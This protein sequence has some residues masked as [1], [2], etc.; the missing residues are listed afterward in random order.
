M[1]QFLLAALLISSF[2]SIF[3]QATPGII[4]NVKYGGSGDDRFC[5]IIRLNNGSYIC[6]G[7][8][9]STNGQATGNHGGSD[10][11]IVCI[12]P[13]GQ[14]LWRKVIGGS[15]DD[16]GNFVGNGEFLSPTADGGFYFGGATSSSNGDIPLQR[17]SYDIFISRFDANGNI[18]WKKTYGGS[19]TE[20]MSSIQTTSDGG[21]IF[22]ATTSS[23]SNGDV[24]ANHGSSDVWIVK[25]DETGAIQWNKLF[26][27]TKA[28]T[29]IRMITTTDGGY[30]FTAD[31]SSE[32]GDLTGTVPVGA[33]RRTD[34]WVVKLASDGSLTWQKRIGGSDSDDGAKIIQST[35]GDYYVLASSRSIDGDFIS[36][37]GLYDWAF[38]KLTNGGTV[39]FIK[40]IGGLAW[41][42]SNDLAEAEDGNFLLTGITYSTQMGGITV[43]NKGSS[44]IVLAKVDK[45]NGNLQW[46]STIG[47]T[48]GD[49]PTAIYK[50]PG[51]ETM[52]VGSSGSS[53]G[54]M[55]MGLGGSDAFIIGI[56]PYN[57]VKG[58][59]FY[60]YNGN[61]TKE[62]TEPFVQNVNVTTTKNNVY[63]V[64]SYTESGNYF[65]EVD[66]G[67][68]VTKPRIF[69]ENYY[70]IT[71]DSFTNTFPTYYGTV[72]RNFGLKPIRGKRDLRSALVAINPARAGF[73][74]YY[75]LIC[76]NA[77]TDTVATGTVKLIK[78]S[79]TTYVSSTPTHLNVSGDTITWVY[80]NFK[81]LDTL[82]FNIVID[83]AVP[84][85]IKIGDWIKYVSVIGP[86]MGDLQPGDNTF[87]L[88]HKVTGSYDP[89]D[90]SE[91]HG[92]FYT[93]SAL[94]KREPLMYTI[95]FQNTG[96]DTAF[97]IVVKDTLD[98]KL[99]LKSF[100]LLATSHKTKL[101]IT[102]NI[103]TWKFSN[104]L[105]PDSNR[106][107]PASH[108]F[109]TYRIKPGNGVQVNDTIRN[110]ASIYFDYNEPIQTNT[111]LTIVKL[112][113]VPRP[114][115]AGAIDSFC[116][117]PKLKLLN[118]PVI[119]YEATVAV[120]V[121]NT[122]LNV[123]DD[124]TVSIPALLTP[125]IH[126]FTVIYTNASLSTAI[127]KGFKMLE[128]VT[129]RVRLMASTTQVNDLQTPV[130]ITATNVAGGGSAPVY[131]FARDVNF[132][133]SLQAEGAQNVLTLQAASMT[134][135]NNMFYVRMKTSDTCYTAQTSTDSVNVR[136]SNVTGIIDPAY[137]DRAI[138]ISP[139]PFNGVLTING[140]NIFSTMYISMYDATG[141][142]V[143]NQVTKGQATVSF[144]PPVRAGICYLIIRNNKQQ[145]IG[146]M[147][148]IKR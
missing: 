63:S 32:D 90:K 117:S 126:T 120:K 31:V 64:S 81:P 4:S 119:E 45:S 80:T 27:G 47:G 130:T 3:S 16:G 108:G 101:I 143:Y 106:N 146:A 56:A 139:N 105:L 140:L 18:L 51:Q 137:P 55:S 30:I 132:T 10:F 136:L 67:T 13:K 118:M 62:A 128:K 17:G 12:S 75:K 98:R 39:S 66:S 76:Y 145:K 40:S 91:A 92:E 93:P 79:R 20:F 11:F 109:I 99:D 2:Q 107:E 141:K 37:S 104:I 8:T 144:N 77:G 85:A 49:F 24:P 7:N 148:L 68:F 78:D 43:P 112:P 115:F 125:G 35:T 86:A 71:P 110:S 54:D 82:V 21:C 50:A 19:S 127:S 6:S 58:Y 88:F 111:N 42:S 87:T 28:E 97:N 61:G 131:T 15:A 53:D 123:Q 26:G 113:N 65:N 9:L 95:R 122:S 69:N 73:R 38:I 116:T 36:N 34:I 33:F 94:S 52:I 124:S 135:G 138:T 72:T 83:L 100:E 60:D 70:V 84:P 1:K 41:D 121:D 89:N 5:D 114:E 134:T 29:G 96:T 147:K 103:C 25:L 102:D 44:D 14:L 46:V 23:S 22:S 133:S 74:S 48:Y 129:P 142:L 57:A 59:V